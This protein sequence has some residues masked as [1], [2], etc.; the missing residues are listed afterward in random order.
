MRRELRRSYPDSA[1]LPE[2]GLTHPISSLPVPARPGRA[3]PWHTTQTGFVAHPAGPGTQSRRGV[4][5]DDEEAGR[6]YDLFRRAIALIVTNSMVRHIWLSM[7]ED[8][9]ARMSS[10]Q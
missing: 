8:A 9:A 10:L 1:C 4:W 6:S 3:E 7:L 2:C 5:H